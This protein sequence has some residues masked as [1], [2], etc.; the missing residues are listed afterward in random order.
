MQVKTTSGW[1]G[2]LYSLYR[3]I[4]GFILLDIFLTPLLDGVAK[5]FATG[6]ANQGYIPDSANIF[7]ILDD[8]FFKGAILIFGS[9]CSILYG[10]GLKD[11]L[12]APILFWL[13]A[14]GTG[15]LFPLAHAELTSF[16]FIFL[17]HL[18]TPDNPWGTWGKCISGANLDWQLPTNLNLAARV[19]IG[20]LFLID[21]SGGLLP[22]GPPVVS[23]IDVIIYSSEAMFIV[24]QIIPRTAN[25]K[26]IFA[27][28]AALFG[29]G[30]PVFIL[31][32]LVF[33]PTIPDDNKDAKKLTVFFDGPCGL[34]HRWILFL[35]SEATNRNA[36]IFAPIQGETFK[37]L[38]GEVKG[39]PTSIVVRT[40][41]EKLLYKSDA[42]VE[43]L[44]TLGSFWSFCGNIFYLIPKLI[45]DALYTFIANIRY[46]LFAKQ[47]TLC[48]LVPPTLSIYF[49]D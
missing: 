12:I 16:G 18:F 7:I 14:S 8:P 42:I 33:N 34:C 41:D 36:F 9:V 19:G 47:K 45:R 27:L 39:D 26:L 22:P 32:L 15:Y 3:L 30:Y 17:I 21:L 37:H 48:P 43:I 31:G 29:F 38:V 35:L 5:S 24:M 4:V 23:M 11:K 25:L 13:L 46:Q 28:T 40:K 1:T 44:K 49:R 2:G 10:L 6:L 20:Y